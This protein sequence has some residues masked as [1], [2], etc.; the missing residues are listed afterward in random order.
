MLF[1]RLATFLKGEGYDTAI[2]DYCDGDMASNRGASLPLI[3]YHD[4]KPTHLPINSIIIFQA[5]T[6]WSIFPMLKIDDDSQLFFIA[7]IPQNF[8]PLLPGKLRS[9]MA[10]GE[11]LAKLFW[12]TLL[13]Q[14]YFKIKRFISIINKHNALVF[15]DTDIVC[16]IENN[17][18]IRLNEPK[19]L[20]L[21]SQDVSENLYIKNRVKSQNTVTMGWIGRLADF[22][23]SILN[24]VLE[25]AFEYSQKNR[26]NV[27][28]HIV[29]SG[30]YEAELLTYNSTY[31]SIIRLSHVAPSELASYML[32]L[33][34]IFAMGTTALDAARIGIPTVRLD[35]SFKK[36]AHNYGYKMLYEVDGFSLGDRIGS[37]GFKN[38]HHTFDDLMNMLNE[39]KLL[40][41]RKCFSYYEKNHSINSS[42]PLF[43]DYI[44]K[45]SLK[46]V[47]LVNNRVLISFFY[48]TWKKIR[49]LIR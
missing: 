27:L 38:G 8:Y 37:N 30:E 4:D 46:W 43:L 39:N 13:V 28:F 44:E 1:L 35:Y 32:K 19:I 23:I 9:K 29:G 33:D 40:L 26:Q 14:D 21:F 7:T 22:K 45:S 24:K 15:L 41:S 17:L 10:E 42:A 5:M 25:D 20:P 3:T 2:V 36:V 31:F 34:I 47:E 16:N 18:R 6:P 12:H 11:L 48:S 49:D